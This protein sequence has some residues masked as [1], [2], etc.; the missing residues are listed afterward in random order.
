MNAFYYALL[1]EDGTVLRVSTTARCI[2]SV[3]LV[4]LP[5]I[6]CLAALILL[7][8]ILIGR[9]LTLQLIRPINDMAEHLDDPTFPAA[10]KELAPFADKIRSQHVDIL[11]AAKARQD[12]TANVSHELKT[13]LTAISGYSELIENHMVT[14]EAEERI[15]QQ[16]R[17]NANRLLA[18]IN[19]IIRLSCRGTLSILTFASLRRNAP[20]S[21]N[22]TRKR[23]G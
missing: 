10:Y 9:T 4:V 3:F 2:S 22:L 5:M 6:V 23:S 13:P 15:A 18:L 16:I 21:C 19:D 11:S 7:V 17:H 1:L 14:A 8:C 20:S 12:F